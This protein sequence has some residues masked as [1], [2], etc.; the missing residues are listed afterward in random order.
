MSVDLRV[1]HFFWVLQE[2]IKTVS[3]TKSWKKT[4]LLYDADT[5]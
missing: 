3:A 5:T 2:Q 4:V 1:V